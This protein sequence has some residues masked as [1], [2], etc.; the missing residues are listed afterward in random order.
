VSSALEIL[1]HKPRRRR[2]APPLL[3]IHGAYTGAWCWDRYFLPHFCERGFE[4]YAV[5]LRGH[6]R[7]PAPPPFDSATLRDYADDVRTA[8]MS[9]GRPPILVAH[10]MGAVIAQRIARRVGAPAMVLL[11]PVPPQGLAASVLTLAMRDPPLFLALSLMQVGGAATAELKRLRDYLFSQS[12]AEIEALL[13]LS[14]MQRESQRALADLAWPQHAWIIESVGIP[15]LVLGALDDAFFSVGMTTQAAAFHG[16]SPHF[17]A[18]T[19]HFMMLEPGWREVADH[20]IEWIS[21]LR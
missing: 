7:S 5:S 21:E 11:A 2:A 6:G 9:L 16:V 4:A 18:R 12:V 13:H 15:A 20:I 14:R 10:S 8:A 17:F 19:A 1:A 3:F